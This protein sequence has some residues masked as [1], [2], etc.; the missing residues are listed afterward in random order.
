MGKALKLLWQS[1]KLLL[2]VY[3]LSQPSASSVDIMSQLFDLLQEIMHLLKTLKD[4]DLCKDIY[5]EL[6]V[7]KQRMFEIIDKAKLAVQHINVKLTCFGAEPEHSP[8]SLALSPDLAAGPDRRETSGWETPPTLL[9]DSP[10][11]LAPSQYCASRKLAEEQDWAC[12]DPA[13]CEECQTL[14]QQFH[15][16][17]KLCFLAGEIQN[18]VAQT[19]S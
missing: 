14:R 7:F 16:A 3:N 19:P 17:E 2:R 1:F 18:L 11:S 15:L 8:P 4:K 13:N 10:D 6:G 12:E 5:W 9:A